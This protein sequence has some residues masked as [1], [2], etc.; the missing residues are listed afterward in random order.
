M[1]VQ[2][3]HET[4][5][6]DDIPNELLYIILDLCDYDSKLNISLVNHHFKAL[7]DSR[8]ETEHRNLF[9]EKI[10]KP[11]GSKITELKIAHISNQFYDLVN[12]NDG[13]KTTTDYLNLGDNGHPDRMSIFNINV[14]Y[15]NELIF[16]ICSYNTFTDERDKLMKRIGDK[17]GPNSRLIILDFQT[18]FNELLDHITHQ[19]HRRKNSVTKFEL[20]E[21]VYFYYS[22]D[23]GVLRDRLT[24]T[25]LSIK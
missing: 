15:S 3:P 16:Q 13:S 4:L 5:T 17:S 20:E 19:V 2:T 12:E 8:V 25:N 23:K 11:I 6:L 14:E 24:H 18:I 7:V 21:H 1:E 22:D 10:E 9:S